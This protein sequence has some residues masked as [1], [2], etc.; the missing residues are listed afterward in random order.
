MLDTTKTFRLGNT[1]YFECVYR[2]TMGVSIDP[3]N[4][5]WKITSSRGVVDSN[6]AS[7]GGPYKRSTGL[8]YIFWTSTD[9]GD[10]VLE[11]TGKIMN[12]D[13]KIRRPFK[14]IKTGTIY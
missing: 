6:S 11:F 7:N 3:D 5:D 1:V 2:N 10:Y 14:V 12:Q 13:V 4:P 8:W 9:V